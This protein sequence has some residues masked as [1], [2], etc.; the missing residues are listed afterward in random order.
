MSV[1]PVEIHPRL[2]VIVT[3]YVPGH[4]ESTPAFVEPVDQLNDNPD[5]PAMVAVASPVQVPLHALYCVVNT[6]GNGAS[7]NTVAVSVTEQPMLSVT[8]TK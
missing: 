8:V 7:S 6:T 5:N 2:S 4:K 1:E 3:V